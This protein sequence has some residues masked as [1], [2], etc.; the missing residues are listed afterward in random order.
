MDTHPFVMD[1]HPLV[2]GEGIADFF[3]VLQSGFFADDVANRNYMIYTI[4]YFSI[5]FLTVTMLFFYGLGKLFSLDKPITA[6]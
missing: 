5:I 2:M 1:I 4:I 6:L 3:V